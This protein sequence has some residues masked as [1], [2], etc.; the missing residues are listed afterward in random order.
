MTMIMVIL[1]VVMTKVLIAVFMIMILVLYD[2]G[3][4]VD[5]L[6]IK[7]D[8]IVSVD[9]DE[10]V[11]S[12]LGDG[13]PPTRQSSVSRGRRGGVCMRVASGSREERVRVSGRVLVRG[14]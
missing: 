10:L 2:K 4:N 5:M 8:M 14:R 9:L 6:N 3:I 1:L 12:V 7:G 13:R 11:M